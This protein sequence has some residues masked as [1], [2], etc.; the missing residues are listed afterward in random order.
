[1]TEKFNVDAKT[2]FNRIHAALACVF[3]MALGFI[4]QKIF[5]FREPTINI[6]LV[7]CGIIIGIVRL[8]IINDKYAWQVATLEE[9]REVK[10]MLNNY[11]SEYE[12]KENAEKEKQRK[13]IEEKKEQEKLDELKKNIKNFDDLMNDPQIK[14]EAEYLR[15]MY[16]K[17]AYDSYIEKKAKELELKSTTTQ[18]SG[19]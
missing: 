10:I 11:I 5:N 4:S 8:F 12:K 1:M 17:S 19:D 2:T 7:V 16:G 3:W 15:K 13:I 6:V 9:I 14:E 18:V